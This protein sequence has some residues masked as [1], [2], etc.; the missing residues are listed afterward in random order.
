M[1]EI[2][3][4][5]I[6]DDDRGVREAYREILAQTASDK[7]RVSPL[8]RQGDRLFGKGEAPSVPATTGWET[9]EAG[10][11]EQAIERLKEALVRGRPF[12]LVFLDMKMSGM[13][14]AETAQALW[15]IDPTLK[16]VIV[17]AFS[18]ISPDEIVRAVNR[19]DL[20]YLR[21]PFNPNE[22]KQF[23]RALC[24]QSRLEKE[25]DRLEGKLR[26]ANQALAD[27]NQNLK[28][29]VRQQTEMLIQSEKMA[30]L[31]I[32]AAGVGHEINNPL[33]FIKGNLWSL[34][35]FVSD[36]TGFAALWEELETLSKD[37]LT[38]QITEKI[39]EM[40]R[41]GESRNMNRVLQDL[42]D[43]IAQTREG[44]DRIR[45][46]V[47]DLRAFSRVDER[48]KSP[49]DVNES[50]EA[51]LNILHSQ[52]KNK[53]TLARDYAEDVPVIAGFPRKLNQAFM[54]ILMN[55][56]QS[57]EARGTISIRTRLVPPSKEDPRG[58]VS[59]EIA[60]T[61]RGMA[62][63]TLSRGLDPIFT[64]KPVGAGGGLGR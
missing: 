24:R 49:V 18:D 7:N 57:I 12:T 56:C 28:E 15:K 32:L 31:G 51:A 48:E 52:M 11:G 1:D 63:E 22:I 3:R 54:N 44:T 27:M 4:I 20:F 45:D 55:A 9:G 60:D 29:R 21:K 33:A 36:I 38:R 53:V 34:G 42:P 64:T 35:E 40:A 62:G 19:E 16:I 37:G 10:S 8:L 25:R 17:T 26:A 14:G 2:Q 59:V 61:G 50:L 39:H 13:D 58:L 43:L 46:I 23:A 30:S 5:L 6:V 47:N 41:Y